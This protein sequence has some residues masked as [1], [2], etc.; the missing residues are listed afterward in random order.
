[1]TQKYS[2]LE[3]IEETEEL[4]KKAKCCAVLS[5]ILHYLSAD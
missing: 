2:K 1:M 5:T 3:L 4:V